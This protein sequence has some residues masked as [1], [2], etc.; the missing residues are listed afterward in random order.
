[1]PYS[2]REYNVITEHNDLGRYN[3]AFQ[4]EGGINR[5]FFANGVKITKDLSVGVTASFLFG[6]LIDNTT[7]YY[8]DSTYFLNG[9]R[10][11][12]MRV[13]DFKLDYGL[14]Y[15]LPIKNCDI[16]LGFTYSQGTKLASKR[17]LFIRNMF[18]G[19]ENMN[20]NPIDT[21]LYKED[22]EVSSCLPST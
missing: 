2:N 16:T 8:P 10:S 3:V 6:T 17:D 21:L 13:S 15:R 22:Q 5:V 1:M 19:Y 14:I 20:D 11:L 7:I 12:D 18:K 9:R 4:G